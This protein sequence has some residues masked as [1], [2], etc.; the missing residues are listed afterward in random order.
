MADA[1]GLP[2]SVKLAVGVT[3]AVMDAVE[4]AL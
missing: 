3:L 4:P 2:L 1:V